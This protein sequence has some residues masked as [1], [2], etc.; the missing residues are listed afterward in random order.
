MDF[1]KR[2]DIILLVILLF[3]CGVLLIPKYFSN[4]PLVAVIYKDG[5]Q[6]E[7]IDLSSVTEEYEIDLEC[8]PQ[9]K[10]TVKKNSIAYTYAECHD[11]LCVN[12]GVLSRPGD[13]A[14]CLPSKT[15]VVIEGK[16]D[17][18]KPDVITY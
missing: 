5:S 9:A 1:I 10:L 18:S 13:I 15:L 17:K 6:I 16:K 4:E 12:T 11:K 7:T 3:I 14:A 2:A 8:N